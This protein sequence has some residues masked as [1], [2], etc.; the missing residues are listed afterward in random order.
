MKSARNRRTI[1][2]QVRFTGIGI[3]SGKETAATISPQPRGGGICFR[4]GGECFGIQDAVLC[5]TR[6][7]TGLSFGDGRIVYTVEHLLGALAG[8]GVDDA[9]IE[10]EGGEA[11]ILDGSAL[12]YA[13]KLLEAGLIGRDEEFACRRLYAPIAIDEGRASIIAVPS[14]VTRLTYVIDYPDTAIG[15]QIKDVVLTR[16]SF[17]SEIA[18][19]RTFG[20]CSEVDAL[21]KEGLGLGGNLDNVVIIGDDGPLNTVGYRLD[22][23]C[24]SHKILDLLGDLALLGS[25]VVAHYIC[26]RCGHELHS[27]LVDRM[28]SV[29]AQNM[30]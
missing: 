7:K 5:D 30:K 14:D 4:F 6:R 26:I 23:E 27:R 20:L 13:E 11:P 2:K 18:P 3:H 22:R 15:V 12:P 21:H 16:E 28:K 29:F 1:A 24:V 19:A 17:M 8:L 9:E 10:I 25:P